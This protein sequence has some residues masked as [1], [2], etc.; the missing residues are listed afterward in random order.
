MAVT[1]AVSGREPGGA[2]ATGVTG[3]AH[4]LRSWRVRAGQRR[5]LGGPLSQVEVATEI[6]MSERWYRD[7]ERGT[8]P[9][10][11]AGVLSRLA[12]TLGLDADE[13]AALHFHAFGG[14]PYVNRTLP[15]RPAD[16]TALQ[17]L[18]DQQ[19][20]RPTYVTDARWDIVGHNSAMAEWFPWVLNRPANLIRWGLTTQEAREQLVDWPQHAYMYLAMLRYSM[21]ER[22]DEPGLAE[23]LHEVLQ[24]PV[25]GRMWAER[26]CIVGNRDGHR[27]RLRLPHIAAAEFHVEAQVLLPARHPG[28]RFVALADVA[29]PNP[30][31]DN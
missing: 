29:T 21:A 26:T 31:D 7:L 18:V 5:G 23:L 17:Q 4:L 14:T 24:D 3:L 16:L 22:P 2:V 6:G 1:G 9:R 12:D 27:F 30:A 28:L 20:P 25:C 8:I 11:D 13:R 10:L 19:M 15:G